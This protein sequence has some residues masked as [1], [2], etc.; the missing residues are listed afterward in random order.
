MTPRDPST[1]STLATPAS[2][3]SP[4]TP[5][6][7]SYC[8][9]VIHYQSYGD[10]GA[11]LDAIACQSLRPQA[12]WVIDADG[13]PAERAKFEALHPEVRFQASPNRG[14]AVAANRLL[15]RAQAEEPAVGFCL[16]LNPDVVLDP[17]FGERLIEALIAR[18]RAALGTGKLLRTDRQTLDSAG[19][20]LPIHR[21]PRDRG[22]QTVDRGQ[23]DRGEYIF[24]ASGAA[25][26]LRCAALADL[27]LEG[28]V[29]DEDFFLYHEDTDLSWRSHLLGWRVYYEPRATAIH[30]R[31]WQKANRFR[32]PAAVRRHSFKNHYLQLIKNES[33]AG[34]LIRLPVLLAWEALRFAHAAIRD[35]QILRGYADAWGLAGR[36]FHKRGVLHARRA[37]LPKLPKL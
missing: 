27:A 7:A 10:L 25:M 28:E 23:Y 37:R 4:A 2:P 17:T 14:Y 33:L 13:D 31:G 30:G 11:C 5:A 24:G 16:L 6:P 9:G 12:V 18:P 22:S 19:I 34:F 35:P 29:F 15:A 32:V 36:A 3:A 21:R 8:V 20:E 26:M 1:P